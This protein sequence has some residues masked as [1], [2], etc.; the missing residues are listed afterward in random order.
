MRMKTYRAANST[1]AFAKVKADL[2]ED[3]VILSNTTVTDNGT[4]CCEIVAAV[5]STPTV[6]SSS[7]QTGLQTKAEVV[8]DALQN[9]VGW[10]QEWSQIKGQIMQLMK[11]Q[12]DPA[13]LTPKQNLAMQYM[14]RE[15]VNDKVLAKIFCDLRSD[16]NRSIVTVLDTLLGTKK[17]SAKNM[18]KTF[19]AFA[20][21]G[22][23]G[24]TSTLVRLA[25]K[26]KKENP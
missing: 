6:P 19:H 22:G 15:E 20:G 24:K 18:T 3:A 25:L 5:D 12:M 9:T 23:S 7:Q 14:E 1:A 11:P 2:G 8:E 17:F 13:Q 16:K 21:P 4:K 10:Q 26:E